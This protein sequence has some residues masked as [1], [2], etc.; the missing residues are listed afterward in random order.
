MRILTFPALAEKEE[1][2]RHKG[3]PLFPEHK[4]IEMQMDQKRIMSEA[5]WAAEYQGHPFLSGSGAI[6]IEK[7]K[8]VPFFDRNNVMSTVMAI[9]KAGTEG[10]DGAFTAIVI[11]SKMRDGTFVIEDVLRGHWAA[12]EREKYI[13]QWADSTRDSLER[14]SVRFT[15]VIE[16]EPGSGGKESAE[17]TIR[18][19]AGHICIADKPGAGRSKELRAEQFQLCS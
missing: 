11:M 7:L 15:V 8:V 18:N 19:L 4:P 14:T 12:L 1:G 16:Q 2:W 5:S 9:D 3:D 6:P 13:K 17:A 10:G